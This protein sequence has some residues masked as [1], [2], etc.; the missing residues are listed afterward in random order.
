ME[1]RGAGDPGVAGKVGELARVIDDGEW[2]DSQGSLM[3][4]LAYGILDRDGERYRLALN[5]HRGCSSCRAY[6]VS[7]RGLAVALPPTLL[8]GARLALA[9]LAGAGGGAGTG[10][11]GAAGVSGAGGGGLAFAGAPIGAKLAVGCLMAVGV[12]A[13]CVALQ[14]ADH[15]PAHHGQVHALG[16]ARS[17]LRRCPRSA[18]PGH[19]P[20]A[21]RRSTA[22]GVDPEIP[23]LG[24]C[25]GA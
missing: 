20:R 21:A 3:R 5:H 24:G 13:G 6:V 23:C 9:G 16:S 1:G 11:S 22:R 7:L 19:L 15:P 18:R 8:P 14:P 10:A 4:A 12:G 2:C 17:A 25:R